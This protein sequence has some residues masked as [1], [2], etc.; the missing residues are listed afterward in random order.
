MP[1][2]FT[3]QNVKEVSQT[4]IALL[5]T[6]LLNKGTAF[7]EAE[8]TEFELHGLLPPYI[9]TIAEQLQRVRENFDR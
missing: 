5:R 7:P 1:S 4:G 6:P 2:N 9:S 8:R 3:L